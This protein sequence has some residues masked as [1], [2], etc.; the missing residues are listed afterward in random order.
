MA[1]DK[2]KR[3][4]VVWLV[5]GL[6]AFIWVG[7]NVGAWI[8][9]VGLPVAAGIEQWRLRVSELRVPSAL[10]LGTIAS[11]GGWVLLEKAGALHSCPNDLGLS[12]SDGTADGLGHVVVGV[13]AMLAWA[14]AFWSGY[15][16]V[17]VRERARLLAVA[18]LASA[19]V[20]AAVLTV[21]AL[22]WNFC[23]F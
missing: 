3:T 8:W 9:I 4:W 12:G 16:A 2:P 22:L 23:G 15:A 1:I 18:M 14:T 19:L 7:V 5:L 13:G 17:C 11:I 6:L 10:L 21:V 20:P